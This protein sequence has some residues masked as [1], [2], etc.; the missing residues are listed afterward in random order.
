MS[1]QRFELSSRSAFTCL[2]VALRFDNVVLESLE[3]F[4]LLLQLLLEPPNLKLL[5]KILLPIHVLLIHMP[6]GGK[7]GG[8]GAYYHGIVM[9]YVGRLLNDT[10][11]GRNG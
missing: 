9:R 8:S 1:D 7:V 4:S 10:V 2:A 3:L 11:T 5:H 6:R